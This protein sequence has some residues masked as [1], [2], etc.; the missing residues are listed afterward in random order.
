MIV[1]YQVCKSQKPA[2]LLR[3]HRTWP[4]QQNKFTKVCEHPQK[5][6]S[7]MKQEH[8]RL[9]APGIQTHEVEQVVRSDDNLKKQQHH[10][11]EELPAE[12]CVGFMNGAAQSPM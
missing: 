8:G 9:L 7:Q 12:C 2:N 3:S 1:L 6:S 4:D 10:E 5:Q 11:C